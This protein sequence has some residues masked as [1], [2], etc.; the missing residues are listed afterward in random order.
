[1]QIQ[2]SAIQS[3]HH[4]PPPTRRHHGAPDPGAFPLPVRPAPHSTGPESLPHN[5]P[6]PPMS[7]P[8]SPPRRHN[9]TSSPPEYQSLQ[10]RPASRTVPQ[11]IY[12]PSRPESTAAFRREPLSATIATLPSP[13]LPQPVHSL[14]SHPSRPPTLGHGALLEQARY[15]PQRAAIPGGGGSP[16]VPTEIG[17]NAASALRG[18]RSSRRGKTHV[19]KACVNCKKAHLSCD[20]QRPCARCVGSGKQVR[21]Q[22]R[23]RLCAICH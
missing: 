17:R 16:V 2:P 13:G 7:N 11:P 23:V 9:P 18:A 21:S 22:N 8:P 20:S 19:Q 1:M 5:Y 10:T 6:S 4:L 15:F 14:Y 12:P 3:R